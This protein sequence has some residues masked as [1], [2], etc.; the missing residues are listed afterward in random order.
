MRVGYRINGTVLPDG[1]HRD[2]YVEHGRFVAEPTGPVETLLEDGWLVPGLVDAH[3]HLAL[4]SPAGEDAP[5]SAR[6]RAS[7]RAHLQAGVLAVREPGSVDHGSTGLGPAD[8]MPRVTAAGRVLA[9]PGRYFPGL[10]REVYDDDVPDAAVEELHAGGGTWA[11]IVGDTPLGQPR[12]TVAYTTEA[13]REA[14][15]RVHEAGGRI[16]IHCSMPA[17]IQAALDAGFDSLEHATFLQR[18]Q[19]PT[20]AAS[21]AAW[22]PTRTIDP[23]IRS[24]ARR[25]HYPEAVVADLDRG[26]DEQADVLCAAVDAGAMVLAGTD[27]GMGPHGMVRGEVALLAIAGI[28][29]D[30]ALGAAS[31]TARSWLGLPGI[32]DGAPADLVAYRADPR[33]DFAVLASPALVLLDGVLLADPR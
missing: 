27:G 4:A 2:V 25:L 29:A 30:V 17:V 22:V 28:P 11:T 12:P 31:W 21:G 6:V 23:E 20:L 32:D 24:L 33:E 1:G 26:L 10:A 9:P 7:G 19:V 8:G 18:D 15:A 13:L 5:L 16:A 3:A 14:A